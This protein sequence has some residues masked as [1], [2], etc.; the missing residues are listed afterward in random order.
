MGKSYSKVIGIMAIAFMLILAAPSVIAASGD[1][2]EE[3]V[4]GY[5]VSLSFVAGQA[6]IGHNE[7]L[8]HITDAQVAVGNAIVTTTAELHEQKTMTTGGGHSAHGGGGSTQVVQDVVVRSATADL[9]AG[10]VAGAYGGEIELAETGHWM[11]TIAFDIQ[12][13]EKS[14][15]FPVDIAKDTSKFGIL[16]TF[17]GINAA[18][19]AG[20][21]LTRSKAIKSLS[22]NRTGAAR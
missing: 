16:A 1:G 6:V 13:T 2:L 20:G 9:A 12:G 7:I 19:I 10:H 5:Q 17:L 3:E 14:V 8:V 15:E 22:K 21:V 4:D 18:F 11:I